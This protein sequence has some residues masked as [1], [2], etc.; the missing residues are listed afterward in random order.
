MILVVAILA[1]LAGALAIVLNHLR[2]APVGYEDHEGFHVVQ[3]LKGSAI[4]RY[5]K[6]DAA[7][8]SALKRAR[9]HS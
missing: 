2:K 9:A 6:A 1:S 8:A 4:L 3:H 7:A 5:S